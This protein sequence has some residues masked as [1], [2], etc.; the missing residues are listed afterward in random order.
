MKQ[1]LLER[2]KS[3]LYYKN[4]KKIIHVPIFPVIFNPFKASLNL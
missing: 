2:F 1:I 4:I 3:V